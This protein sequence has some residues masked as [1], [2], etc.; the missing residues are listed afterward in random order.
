[1]VSLHIS[2][3]QQERKNRA[4]LQKVYL[5]AYSSCILAENYFSLYWLP[6]KNFVEDSYETYQ[7]THKNIEFFGLL[8]IYN[9]EKKITDKI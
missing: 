2:N 8:L 5:P 6:H 3:E 4:H 7:S 1:M 9:K